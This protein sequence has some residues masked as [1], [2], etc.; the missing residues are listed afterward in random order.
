MSRTKV[1]S[2][3]RD[4]QDRYMTPVYSI[5]PMLKEIDW[6]RVSSFHEPCKGD[7]AIYDRI[8]CEKSYSELSE[9]IDYLTNADVPFVDLILT[10]PPFTLATQFFDKAR[11]EAKTVV[12]LNRLNWLGAG[13]RFEWWQTRKPTHIFVLS[14]RPIFRGKTSDACEYGWFCWDTAGLIKKKP[15]IYWLR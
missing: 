3:T 10:N 15:G 2:E 11:T 7:G 6:R 9:G 5:T 1:N 8:F 4:E 12:L 13:K 14:M